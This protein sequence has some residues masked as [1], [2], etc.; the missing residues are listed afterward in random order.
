MR[1]RKG[2]CVARMQKM[3]A[4]LGIESKSSEYWSP[5][6]YVQLLEEEWL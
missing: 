6:L 3:I 4:Q 2:C 1:E 5:L